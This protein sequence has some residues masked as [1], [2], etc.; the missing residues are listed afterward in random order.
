MNLSEY[1]SS[2]S[3]EQLDLEARL[4]DLCEQVKVRPVFKIVL[5]YEL[6]QNIYRKPGILSS[7]TMTGGHECEFSDLLEVCNHVKFNVVSY[8]VILSSSKIGLDSLCL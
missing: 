3:S 2:A 5:Q 7:W 4:A 8:V 1:C 6:M